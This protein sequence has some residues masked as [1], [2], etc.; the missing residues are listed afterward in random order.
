MLLRY[1]MLLFKIVSVLS[2]VSSKM[3][4]LVNSHNE[5]RH[6][7]SHAVVSKWETLKLKIF[8][9]LKIM[10][11]NFHGTCEILLDSTL[12]ILKLVLVRN[13][14]EDFFNSLT[15]TKKYWISYTV[16]HVDGKGTFPYV[17]FI[18]NLASSIHKSLLTPV[19]FL[20]F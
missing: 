4:S 2:L 19:I 7:L 17:S 13:Q 14:C 20:I 16:S 5:V 3:I 12:T 9:Y 6:V 1:K 18:K 8:V 10:T 11:V 15:F